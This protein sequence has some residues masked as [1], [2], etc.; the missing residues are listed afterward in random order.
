[1]QEDIFVPGGAAMPKSVLIVE[2]DHSIRE[3]LRLTLELEGY[4]TTVASNGQDALDILDA[5]TQLPEVMLVDIMMPVLNG[6][7]LMQKVKSIP[8]F[9]EIKLISMSA[10][11][12]VGLDIAKVHIPKPLTINDLLRALTT[13]QTKSSHAANSC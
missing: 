13:V 9:S 6:I 12:V 11:N 1:V 10:M 5:A 3:V 4:Q 7:K 8:S 2:D